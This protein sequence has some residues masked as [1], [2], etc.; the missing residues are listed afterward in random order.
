MFLFL[1][2]QFCKHELVSPSPLNLLSVDGS[3]LSIHGECTVTLSSRALRRS[4]TITFIVA[5]V[6]T[7]I[8][9]LDFLSSNNIIVNC[10]NLYLTD[11]DTGICASCQPAT[12]TVPISVTH[13]GVPVPVAE[14]LQKYSAITQP[15]QFTVSSS[16][17]VEHHIETTTERSIHSKPRQLTRDKFAAAK[18]E[19]GKMLKAGIIQP[20][21]SDWA[22]PLHMVQ[23]SDKTWRPCGPIGH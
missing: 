17:D 6:S 23:K 15:L 4:Y 18:A 1:P 16:T 2:P 9:G 14:L 12:Q 10:K 21:K 22:S 19:Y 8:L 13:E 20:S 11:G 3:S 7:P 5:D